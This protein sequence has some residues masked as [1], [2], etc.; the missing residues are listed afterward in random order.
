LTPFEKWMLW[1]SSIVVGITG[2]VYGGMK[3]LMR[4]DDPY[5][6]VHHPLQPWI[7][8]AHVLAAPFLVFAVGAVYIRH[9]V[10]NWRSGRALGRRS[11]IVTI[12]VVVPMIVTGYLIQT[13]TMPG[14][15][16]GIAI[17]HIVT[18][19]VYL[20]TF[21]VHQGSTAEARRPAGLPKGSEPP[22]DPD[23]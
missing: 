6:A 18:G 13:V 3:Y 10:R 2:I 15:L 19:L 12:V 9:I 20:A 14:W 1:V 8:K 23:A 21:A 17:V 22:P 16:L 4:S 7:L 5:A 11:G